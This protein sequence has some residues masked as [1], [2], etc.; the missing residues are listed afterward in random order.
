M[1]SGQK[2]PRDN[3]FLFTCSRELS[4][5][6]VSW[7]REESRAFSF[8]ATYFSKASRNSRSRTS[9]TKNQKF[10]ELSSS[11]SF[12]GYKYTCTRLRAY[13]KGG[14]R[15]FYLNA[16]FV[17]NQLCVYQNCA[18][19]EVYIIYWRG[20]SALTNLINNNECNSFCVLF[21]T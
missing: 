5:L 6:D 4:A 17:Q 21:F 9:E 11:V 16:K 18:F 20:L 19:R 13:R 8:L 10:R 12:K 14:G 7:W 1:V 2:K 3:D 15:V